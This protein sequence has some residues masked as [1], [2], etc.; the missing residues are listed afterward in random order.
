M[1]KRRTLVCALIVC[2]VAI[3]ACGSLAYFVGEA[4]VTNTFRVATY[5]PDNP[6]E[7]IDPDELFS[8]KI[9][10]SDKDAEGGKN[11][12]GLTYE[13]ILPGSAVEKDP[14]IV[15]T[16]AYSA[17][18][19][20]EVTFDKYS[21][22][23]DADVTD[24]TTVLTDVSDEWTLKTEETAEDT[25]AD[26]VTYVYYREEALAAEAESTLFEGVK[27]PDTLTVDQMSALGQFTISIAGD[28][29]QSDNIEGDVYDAFE[30]FE[31]QVN[32]A[33]P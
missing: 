10:E 7:P 30:L 6:D 4:E 15:N 24:L 13:K 12:E 23:K 5:D 20:M 22:W 3:L 27:I 1:N 29:I 32:P 33:T 17:Y 26:T 16:G 28:A 8:I 31:A 25:E 2:L 11:Y 14:T 21:A 18:V 9:Y 19:R